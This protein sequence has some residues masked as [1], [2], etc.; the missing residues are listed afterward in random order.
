MSLLLPAVV[1]IDGRE[2]AIV[3][4]ACSHDK[5][6]KYIKTHRWIR[7]VAAAATGIEKDANPAVETCCG[8]ELWFIRMQGKTWK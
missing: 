4:V 5:R 8:E 1:Q 6:L 3:V 2:T 7:S